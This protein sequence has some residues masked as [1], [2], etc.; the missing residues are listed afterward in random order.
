MLIIED[1]SNQEC[2]NRI[3]A[4]DI[5][6]YLKFCLQQAQKELTSTLITIIQHLYNKVKGN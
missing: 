1:M 6:N 2:S 3:S 4:K 5:E